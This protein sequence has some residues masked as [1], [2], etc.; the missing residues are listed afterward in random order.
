MKSL[1][2]RFAIIFAFLVTA[3]AAFAADKITLAIFN[4]TIPTTAKRVRQM[5]P[6]IT[7]LLTAELSSDERLALVERADL[8][9]ALREQALGLS[10]AVDPGAAAKVGQLT[11]AKV[12]VAGRGFKTDAQHLVITAN[13][14]GTENGRL[15]VEKAEGPAGD[16]AKLCA[17][18]GKKIINTVVTRSA[19]FLTTTH[20]RDD[21]ISAILKTVKGDKRPG[22]LVSIRNADSRVIRNVG[23]AHVPAAE[24]ELSM[25][26]QRAGFP[27]VEKH[28]DN[29]DV[30]IR[31]DASWSDSSNSGLNSCRVVVSVKAIERESDKTLL[32]ERVEAVGTDT[33]KNAAI[34]AAQ[35]NAA[36]AIATKLLPV[37]SQ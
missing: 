32:V 10:G 29:P 26:L 22:I 4:F 20:S 23:K 5:G 1:K 31:G 3:T 33:D 13:I 15:Y 14:I 34:K 11:G 36:D 28:A 12:L 24:T 2:T 27:I 25:I 18:L 37:L 30:E 7:S 35:S 19:T 17:E 9:K 8:S 6:K 21:R 16:M